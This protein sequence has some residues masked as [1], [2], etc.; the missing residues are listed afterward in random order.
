[1]LFNYQHKRVT[2]WCKSVTST[3][4]PNT[5]R[6]HRLTCMDQARKQQHICNHPQNA[7]LCMHE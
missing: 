3:Q 4:N 1:L 6:D 5:E 2:Q 7:F